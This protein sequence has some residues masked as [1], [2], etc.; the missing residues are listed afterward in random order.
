M[1]PKDLRSVNRELVADAGPCVIRNPDRSPHLLAARAS[2]SDLAIASGKRS[3][4]LASDDSA[5][6]ERGRAATASPASAATR[7][8]STAGTVSVGSMARTLPHPTD[9]DWH[10]PR[11]AAPPHHAL[12][13]AASAAHQV[14]A[15]TTDREGRALRWGGCSRGSSSRDPSQG[16]G[17]P[18]RHHSARRHTD[19]RRSS[20]TRPLGRE[21]RRACSPLLR[22]RA[23]DGR[24]TPPGDRCDPC[25]DPRRDEDDGNPRRGRARDGSG[26]A[27]DRSR[28]SCRLRSWPGSG[29]RP[30]SRP[31]TRRSRLRDQSSTSSRS[32]GPVRRRSSRRVSM[33]A[34]TTAGPDTGRGARRPTPSQ[35]DLLVGVRSMRLRQAPARGRHLPRARHHRTVGEQPHSGR[36]LEP[37]TPMVALGGLVSDCLERC[38]TPVTGARKWPLLPSRAS[39]QGDRAC[40]ALRR[41]QSVDRTRSTL[42]PRGPR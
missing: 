15:S 1:G 39:S 14:V 24:T 36:R 34:P 3:T 17:P 7:S 31:R 8:G 11:T 32:P 33:A 9:N 42:Q 5:V 18:S 25:V 28:P 12:P 4:A 30:R 26:A 37:P 22:D 40:L 27:T 35:R 6:G 2:S 19:R 20:S 16:A 13:A 21:L 23:A 10:G 38:S 41:R 29:G